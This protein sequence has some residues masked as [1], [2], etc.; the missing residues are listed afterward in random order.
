M[1]S[2]ENQLTSKPEL[3]SRSD[4]F[5]LR[6][7]WQIYPALKCPL[8]G[9][10]LSISE[11]RRILKKC[12]YAVKKEKPHEIHK[13]IMGCLAKEN[14]VSRKAERYLKHKYRKDIK[15]YTALSEDQLTDEWENKLLTGN[16]VPSFFSL[17]CFP[18]SAR[19]RSH[20][21]SSMSVRCGQRLRS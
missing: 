1:I 3:S 8:I 15:K 11:Q 21:Q 12:G 7:V 13:M 2:A 10:C 4:H 20:P 14:K 17:C 19:T 6:P 9:M 18:V 16:I 5:I